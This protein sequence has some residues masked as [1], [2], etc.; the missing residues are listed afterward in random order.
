MQGKDCINMDSIGFLSET[1]FGVKGDFLKCIESH[2]RMFIHE[3]VLA[4]HSFVHGDRDGAVKHLE[5]AKEVL[6]S[7]EKDCKP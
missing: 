5:K 1:V 2:I 3:M 7:V 4:V 6:D